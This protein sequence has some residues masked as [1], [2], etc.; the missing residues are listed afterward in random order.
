MKLTEDE[1]YYFDEEAADRVVFFI[2]NHVKHSKGEYGGKNFILESW[3]KK[4]V[5]D[6]F[7]WKN[8]ANGYRK[9]RTAYLSFPRKNGKST[10]I[11]AL[12]LYMLFGD[13][14]PS[15][16]CYLAAG[17]RQQAN[18]VFSQASSMVKMDQSLSS[19]LKVYRNSI[20]HEKSASFLKT[21]SSDAATSFGYNA[22]FIC[23]DEFFVQR[24]DSLWNALTTSVAAR[25]QP[26]T[27]A[28]TTA[29]YNKNSICY[30]VRE[31]GEKVL[32]GIIDDP[33]FYFCEYATP[34]EDDWTTEE[35]WKMANPALE[36][37]IVKIE[38]LRN[39][40]EKAQRMPSAEASFRMLHLNQWM[41]SEQK[42]ISH[43]DWMKC[44]LGSVNINDFKG[45][46][47]YA[48]LDLA[49]IRD[50][51]A[52]VLLFV[53]DDNYTVVPY[54]FTPQENAFIRSRRDGVD[55][56]GWASEG[57]M[58]LTPGDVTDYDFVQA[59]I[60]EIAEIVDLKCVNYDR[61]NA[62]QLVINLVNEGIPMSPYGQGFLSMSQPTRHLEKIVLNKELNH[63]GNPILRWMVSNLRMKVDASDNIKPDKAKS[64][65]KIDGVVALIMAIGASMNS[66]QD[67]ESS[68]NERGITFI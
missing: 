20:T 3:Q 12:S 64:T 62:S 53:E 24:D 39:E 25:T 13:K 32:A 27:I 45:V 7:G 57:Y 63:G 34:L 33:T 49:S 22:S 8:R 47:C 2:E 58:D 31:Y 65:E 51:T 35:A 18:I 52:L 9:F 48:G 50:V 68:Y 16:E 36:S 61:W 38:Y 1:N 11:S 56:M 23:M 28:I 5:R 67:D 55:Y 19:N 43:K 40:C 29:G 6:I 60:M 42:W 44:N 17:D 26:L 14:E 66:E 59:K 10:L 41:S 15:A 30:K 21:I 46:T 54:F 4:I 37:G